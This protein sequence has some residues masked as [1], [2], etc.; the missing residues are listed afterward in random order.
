MRRL[1]IAGA[2]VIGVLVLVAGVGFVWYAIGPGPTMSDGCGFVLRNM[3]A[4]AA[5]WTASYYS[6][7]ADTR[8]LGPR[9]E[10]GTL[11]SGASTA[12]RVCTLFWSGFPGIHLTFGDRAFDFRTDA[13]CTTKV[14]VVDAAG[15]HFAGQGICS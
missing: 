11:P 2:L 8:V 7:R 14:I 15:F 5:A 12:V 4:D 1:W 13:W 10:R 6:D 9:T 3:T